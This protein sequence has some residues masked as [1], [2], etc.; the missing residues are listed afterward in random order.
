MHYNYYTVWNCF[1]NHNSTD[2]QWCTKRY[3]IYNSAKWW[4]AITNI[5]Y[6]S[7]KC[8]TFK[9]YNKLSRPE[10]SSSNLLA[11]LSHQASFLIPAEGKN[12]RNTLTSSGLHVEVGEGFSPIWFPQVLQVLQ[13]TNSV[14][15]TVCIILVNGLT[16]RYMGLGASIYWI[17][18]LLSLVKLWPW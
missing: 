3:T 16:H 1:V 13:R 6:C 5:I 12:K 15:L 11:T 2:G 17:L 7:A 10:H 14:Q 8:Q 9:V 18:F 4:L